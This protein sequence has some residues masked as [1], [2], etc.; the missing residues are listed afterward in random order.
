[1]LHDLSIEYTLNLNA[2][3]VIVMVILINLCALSLLSA[4]IFSPSVNLPTVWLQHF[5]CD[6]GVLVE[7]KKVSPNELQ[8]TFSLVP[9]RMVFKWSEDHWGSGKAVGNLAQNTDI[10]NWNVNKITDRH[11]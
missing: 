10:F 1:M 4:F 11:L 8:A 9:I 6:Y 3:S 7:A 5:H 2:K